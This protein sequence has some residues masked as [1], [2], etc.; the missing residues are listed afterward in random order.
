MSEFGHIR[1]KRLQDNKT[2]FCQQGEASRLFH[3][4][5]EQ[6]NEKDVRAT[7]YAIQA[8]LRSPP[9][10]RAA[11]ASAIRAG[12][13]RG[14]DVWPS[15]ATTPVT[16]CSVSC[17]AGPASESLPTVVVQNSV[18]MAACGDA[19]LKDWDPEVYSLLVKEKQRQVNGIELIASENF[20]SKAVMECLG[21]CMT[22][23]YSEGLP[24]ARYYGGNEHVD[25]LENMCRARALKAFNLDDSK[26]GVNVQPYSGSPLLSTQA[27]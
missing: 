9:F 24:G 22:N 8:A 23:K 14:V 19:N 5:G 3:R 7:S 18:T 11:Q 20:T 10:A 2:P 12:L 26:W 27:C 1:A 16:L 4:I 21:S 6:T 13:I 17:N 15:R 25:E